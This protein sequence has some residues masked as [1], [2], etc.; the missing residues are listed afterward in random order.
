ME[1]GVPGEHAE[2]IESRDLDLKNCPCKS[3]EQGKWGWKVLKSTSLRSVPR[4]RPEILCDFNGSHDGA[5][6]SANERYDPGFGR[7]WSDA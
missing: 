2:A 5:R 3:L 1:A 4:E 6:L 7:L